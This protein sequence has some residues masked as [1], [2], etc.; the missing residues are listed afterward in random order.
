[1]NDI[2]P[3]YTDLT[4]IT[5]ICE[6][7]REEADDQIVEMLRSH[8]IV[9]PADISAGKWLIQH[10]TK[11]LMINVNVASRVLMYQLAMAKFN[12][13]KRISIVASGTFKRFNRRRR[14][15]GGSEREDRGTFCFST[16]RCSKNILASRL[17]R[18]RQ[19]QRKK[20]KRGSRQG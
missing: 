5:E 4:S 11:L 20:S 19:L 3:Y 15:R 8:T 17:K 18:R 2:A 1:M 14:R 6:T 16:Q 7:I 13:F 12:G 9:G 10:G